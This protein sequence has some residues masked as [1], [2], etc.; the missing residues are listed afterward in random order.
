MPL[1]P[2]TSLDSPLV[3]VRAYSRNGLIIRT[4]PEGTA[5]R[6]SQIISGDSPI[7]PLP[8]SPAAKPVPLAELQ[9]LQ[10]PSSDIANSDR[11]ENRSDPL[12]SPAS[13]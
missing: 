11:R 5:R 13:T 3:V 7:A 6:V 1:R 8:R 4:D 9:V 12:S 2:Y 10:L